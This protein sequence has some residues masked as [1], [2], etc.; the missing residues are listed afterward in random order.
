[1][2]ILY[3]NL[4]A[5]DRYDLIMVAIGCV[6]VYL[7]IAKEMEPTLLLP[8]GFGAILVNIPFS[9]AL[10]GPIQELY[11]AG[12][13]NELFPLLLFIG[14]GAMID[15]TPLL[16][17]PKL[18]IFGA[19]AQFGIFF[20]L[21]LSSFFGFELKDAASIAIIGAADGPTSILV[22]DGND[23]EIG[24][25]GGDTTT[26]FIETESS[27]EKN[28]PVEGEYYYDLANVVLYLYYYDELPDNYISKKEARVLGWEGGTPERY[29]EGSAI[30]GDRFGNRECVLPQESGRTYT[31]CDL[32]TDG[33]SSRGAKRIVVSN[34]GLI[35]YTDDHYKTFTLLYG[36][37]D[38]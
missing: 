35:Y 19:A 12:I 34:D 33:K 28:V 20:T 29:L 2:D 24:V 22:T 38:E 31:E 3:T 36:D 8:M 16:T 1:M 32:N 7:A 30:G 37:P 26:I 17:N 13:A 25:I 14:I 18:M 27:K 11:H 5:F 9:D 4:L 23:E 6:L 10:T 15:F 21:F